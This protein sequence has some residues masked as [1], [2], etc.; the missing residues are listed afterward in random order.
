MILYRSLG[1]AVVAIDPGFGVLEFFRHG[2]CLDGA[3]QAG[4][5]KFHVD[6][7]AAADGAAVGG[8]HVLIVAA[9][10]NAVAAAHEDHCLG[11]GEHVVSADWTITVG[12]AL[13]AAVGV[14]DGYGHADTTG[15]WVPASAVY[16]EANGEEDSYLAMKEVLA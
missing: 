10:M 7:R 6:D 15:L 9:V 1:T 12:G 2:L 11:R 13:N 3:G 5:L 4:E 14:A 16:R 8:L